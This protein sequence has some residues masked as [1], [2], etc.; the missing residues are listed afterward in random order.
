MIGPSL[1]LRLPE[2]VDVIRVVLLLPANFQEP[3]VNSLHTSAFA[4]CP[5]ESISQFSSQ[6]RHNISTNG[7][8]KPDQHRNCLHRK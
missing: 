1:C 6:S 4:L 2:L 7:Y 8:T 5:D 3:V